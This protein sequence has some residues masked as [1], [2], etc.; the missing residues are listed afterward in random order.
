MLGTVKNAYRVEDKEARLETDQEA[1]VGNRAL[2]RPERNTVHHARAGS[3]RSSDISLDLYLAARAPL[4][5][6]FED[7]HPLLGRIVDGAG[8]DS[9]R[10]DLRLRLRLRQAKRAQETCCDHCEAWGQ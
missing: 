1:G 7:A 6:L 2:D 10:V 4:H 8:A 3:Q 9:Q 5:A